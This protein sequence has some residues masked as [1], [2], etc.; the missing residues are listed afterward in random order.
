M[1]DERYVVET[2][3]KE[4]DEMSATDQAMRM[5]DTW[6]DEVDKKNT[7]RMK[8]IVAK[9]GWPTT[10]IFGKEAS[11]N[12]WLLVQHADLDIEF[13]EACLSL[14]KKLPPDEVSLSNIAYLEDRVL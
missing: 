7:A 3:K 11:N 6:N 12:A 10:S 4:L 5:S 8:A 2:V 9:F 13:Q 1:S 14:M